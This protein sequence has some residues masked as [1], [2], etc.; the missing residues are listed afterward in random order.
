M[1]RWM[2]IH[3]HT[4]PNRQILHLSR[5]FLPVSWVS[6]E[7]SIKAFIQWTSLS[8]S[9]FFSEKLGI[10]LEIW[11]KAWVVSEYRY[12]FLPDISTRAIANN[13]W[14][15]SIISPYTGLH[16]TGNC[17]RFRY[18]PVCFHYYYFM[19]TYGIAWKTHGERGRCDRDDDDVKSRSVLFFGTRCGE[20]RLDCDCCCL[21]AWRWHIRI[22]KQVKMWTTWQ[23]SRGGIPPQKKLLGISKCTLHHCTSYREINIKIVDT[24]VQIKY[25]ATIMHLKSNVCACIL[26]T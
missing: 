2:K 12:D 24:W 11:T 6:P 3:A 22:P 23:Q 8:L 9:T 16:G 21:P 10:F 26:S 25:K 4:H 19:H 1:K 13:E 14:F 5:V 17:I 18:F 15:S 20:I 7:N